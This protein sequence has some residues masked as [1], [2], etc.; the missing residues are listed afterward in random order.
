[1]T[2][3]IDGKICGESE[4]SVPV[5]DHG[6]LYGDGVF[7]G[8]R[9]Y[10][11]RV[12]R[13]DDHLQRLVHG[14]RALHLALPG[15]LAGLRRIV[16]QTVQAHGAPQAY[17]RLVVTRGS[18]PLGIDPTSCARPRVVCIADQVSLYSE[19]QALAGLD[20]VTASHRRPSAD[21][22]DPRIKTL[23]YLNNVLAKH[24]AKVRGADDALLLNQH[25]RIA[26]ASAANVFVVSEGVLRTPPTADGALEGITRRTVMELAR[27]AGMAVE[28]RSLGRFDLFSADEAFLTGTG[29]RLV[30]VRSLD[31]EAIGRG[32]EP[33]PVV[34]RLSEAFDRR[35]FDA[36]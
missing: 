20:L 30:R 10:G 36:A 12:F 24:E 34:G 4:A 23:N 15:G 18:G 7:E 5:W 9:V 33:G 6:L 17:V 8:L 25:G 22:L 32:S 13:L 1:M 2:V 3:C 14:A 16:E 11:G 26:E 27:S 31:G 29:A 21:V 35:C 19:A 28:E